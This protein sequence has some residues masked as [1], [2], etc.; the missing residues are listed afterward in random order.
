MAVQKTGTRLSSDSIGIVGRPVYCCEVDA[1]S[2][3]S[4]LQQGLGGAGLR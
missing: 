3:P 4:K 1:H 2:K